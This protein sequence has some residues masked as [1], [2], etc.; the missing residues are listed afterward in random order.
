MLWMDF[1]KLLA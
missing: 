1:V